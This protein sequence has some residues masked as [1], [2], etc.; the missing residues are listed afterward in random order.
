MSL[1]LLLISSLLSLT[2]TAT[3]AVAA[4]AV[5]GPLLARHSAR[6]RRIPHV[7]PDA[8]A[9]PPLHATALLLAMRGGGGMVGSM[10]AGWLSIAPPLVALVASVL[11]KQ[12]VLALILG[13]W[14]GTMVLT[15]GAPLSSL[16]RVFDTYV[17]RAIAD[18]D[19]AGVMLFTLL[20]GGTIGLVQKSGG[21]LGLAH[22]LMSF[23]S[24]A[25]R[26][27]GCAYALGTIIFFDDYSSVL[28]VGNSLQP[29]LPALGL[30]PERLAL[31]I[32]IVGEASRRRRV[33]APA[34]PDAASSQPPL[35]N[36]PPR[37]PLRQ[38]SS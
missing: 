17:V 3:A 34:S 13:V 32:H 5:S 12:V 31:V 7:D 24:S 22:L 25:R 19:H 37:P 18:K 33:S 30:A 27:L 8:A 2:A 29:V 38:A 16:L 26:A 21:G 4:P 23:M 9:A 28:I 36:S 15:G 35:P 14:T 20:L 1:P 11:L 10:D 6:S